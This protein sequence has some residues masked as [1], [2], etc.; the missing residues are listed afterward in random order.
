MYVQVPIVHSENLPFTSCS[1]CKNDHL[2]I[3]KASLSRIK[4]IHK[5][6]LPSRLFI[7]RKFSSIHKETIAIKI[8]K[9]LP[10][11][12]LSICKNLRSSVS[13]NVLYS[14]FL[15]S[16]I[17]HYFSAYNKINNH[18]ARGQIYA[19]E[20]LI[21]V[22]FGLLWCGVVVTGRVCKFTALLTEM[23]HTM[24]TYQIGNK[25]NHLFSNTKQETNLI[26][27]SRSHISVFFQLLFCFIEVSGSVWILISSTIFRKHP[28][29]I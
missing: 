29:S 17:M 1:Y 9:H 13:L 6:V 4:P 18:C 8:I 21:T 19:S 14:R 27:Y 2:T 10:S 28:Y 23:V 15:I 5:F 22:S 20:L 11:S 26:T 3:F 16:R 7:S 25:S 12:P 24:M